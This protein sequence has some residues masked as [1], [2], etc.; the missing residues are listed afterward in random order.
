MINQSNT[1]RATLLSAARLLL[2]RAEEARL[3]HEMLPWLQSVED[4]LARLNDLNNA[5]LL[6]ISRAA[7]QMLIARQAE[8]AV[9][10]RVT[11]L[12]NRLRA[13]DDGTNW[14]AQAAMRLLFPEGASVLT[15]LSGNV[16]MTRYEGFSKQLSAA[17]LPAAFEGDALMIF[18]AIG[19][20]SDALR[21]KEQLKIQRKM[22][23]REA[24]EADAALRQA[25]IRLERAAGLHM[26]REAML[27]WTEP[28][29]ALSRKA[30]RA[31]P[32]AA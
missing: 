12:C 22:A 19:S 20:F 30:E 2:Q 32:E 29:R 8:S 28:V 15:R 25:L 26:S 13:E 7:E 17:E 24:D 31:L 4:A 18:S 10:A 16:L 27:A 14:L 21:D 23:S 9:N 6:A 1:S 3:I 5:R 11:K